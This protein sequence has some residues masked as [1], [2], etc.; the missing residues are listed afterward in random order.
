[1]S[2]VFFNTS[3]LIF[4]MF[5]NF[6]MLKSVICYNIVSILSLCYFLFHIVL[7]FVTLLW[8]YPDSYFSITIHFYQV[9]FSHQHF[10]W[11]VI[12]VT[13]LECLHSFLNFGQ[14]LWPSS[15]LLATSVAIQRPSF[16]GTGNM[17][18]STGIGLLEISS[19]HVMLRQHDM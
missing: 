3:C 7:H 10:I 16:C 19:W 12:Q 1:M 14:C 4:I 18:L 13:W 9:I 8:C 6:I 2:H 5:M 17:F 15:F 11:G